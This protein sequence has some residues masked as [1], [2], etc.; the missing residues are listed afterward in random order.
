MNL[1][2][3]LLFQFYIAI[4]QSV[5]GST[6]APVQISMAPVLTKAQCTSLVQRIM[7]CWK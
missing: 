7:T 5:L 1:P 6:Q 4:I 3:E 2:Q